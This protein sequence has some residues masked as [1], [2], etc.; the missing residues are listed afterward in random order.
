MEVEVSEEEGGGEDGRGGEVEW[1][2]AGLKSSECLS[3]ERLE[4][5]DAR[6]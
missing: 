6:L 2:E 4:S 1:G 5:S 3:R